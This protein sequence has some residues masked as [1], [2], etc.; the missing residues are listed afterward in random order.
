MKSNDMKIDT[1][2]HHGWENYYRCQKGAKAWNEVPDEFLLEH[3][4]S[5]LPAQ[6]GN[7][8]DV[9]SGDGRNTAPFLGRDYNVISTDLSPSALAS[10]RD[11]CAK[12]GVGSPVL[13]A[14]DFMSLE[15]TEY[16]FDVAVCFN[17]I[18]HFPS[19]P[20]VL[21]KMCKLLTHGGKA[22][23]NAFTE[24][25]VAFGV[26]ERL[27][28]NTFFYRNT[29]STFTS[30]GEIKEILSPFDMNVIHSETRRWEE[31]DHGD[32]RTGKHTHEACFFIVE[33]I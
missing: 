12:D 2:S 10:F 23:F 16:Q 7:I 11:R 19:I 24:N 29:L 28:E 5:L 14:G 17:G 1:V 30:E 9:A 20:Q 6:G 21:G 31:D 18:S 15:F 22:V 27:Q 33:R 25:D 13:L 3:L 8:I 4:E 32:Y 26:G